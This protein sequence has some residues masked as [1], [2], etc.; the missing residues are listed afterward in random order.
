MQDQEQSV[1][2]FAVHEV[3][4]MIQMKLLKYYPTCATTLHYNKIH[5]ITSRF[6]LVCYDYYTLYYYVTLC[7]VTLLLCYITLQCYIT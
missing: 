4:N 6:D 2:H 7:H 3:E 5:K 1:H